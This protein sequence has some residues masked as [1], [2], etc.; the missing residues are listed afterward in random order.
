MTKN[1]PT[2]EEKIQQ[3]EREVAWFESDEFTLDEAIERY[4]Q[5]AA[6]SQA[7]EQELHKLEQTITVVTKE[8]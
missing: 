3:L 6:A 8:D 1:N 4:Q 2:I 5:V 7:I